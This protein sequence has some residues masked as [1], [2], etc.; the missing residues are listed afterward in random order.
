MQNHKE[1]IIKKIADKFTDTFVEQITDYLIA[2]GLD[3]TD[4]NIELVIKEIVN[5]YKPR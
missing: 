4:E 5:I 2:Y 3:T 1:I